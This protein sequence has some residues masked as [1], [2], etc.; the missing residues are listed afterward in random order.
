M[1]DMKTQFK[2]YITTNPTAD[3]RELVQI[4]KQPY[5]T[6]KL[7]QAEL[8]TTPSVLLMEPAPAPPVVQKEREELIIHPVTNEILPKAVYKQ[9]LHKQEIPK[10]TKALSK[11]SNTTNELLQSELH[12]TAMTL[13]DVITEYMLALNNNSLIIDST[14]IRNLATAISTVQQ[15]FFNHQRISVADN[16]GSK[17]VSA[18]RTALGV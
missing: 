6:L 8:D 3:L 18:L 10:L 12:N 17:V 16:S 13:L 1:T 5:T 14:D 9:E 7:W 11:Q 2:Q 4:F 15:A